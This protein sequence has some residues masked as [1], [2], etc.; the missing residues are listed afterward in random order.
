MDLMC[1]GSGYHI[2]GII[3]GYDHCLQYQATHGMGAM[4][5]YCL[6]L[7]W[8]RSLCSAGNH[9]CW[10][11]ERLWWLMWAAT[12]QPVALVLPCLQPYGNVVWLI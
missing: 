12:Q 8:S 10:V 1:C 2:V 9:C 11:L 5:A 7:F 4:D 3:F 6:P